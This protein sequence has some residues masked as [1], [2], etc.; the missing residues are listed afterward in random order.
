MQAL[1]EDHERFPHSA[2]GAEGFDRLL[3]ELAQIMSCTN[4]FQTDE[5]PDLGFTYLEEHREQHLQRGPFIPY[6]E[7]WPDYGGTM[8]QTAI[9]YSA[10]ESAMYHAWRTCKGDPQGGS[11]HVSQHPTPAGDN[12]ANL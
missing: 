4:Q 9:A 3:C 11:W 2:S 7:W 6:C 8:M 5:M 1:L 10:S 12:T